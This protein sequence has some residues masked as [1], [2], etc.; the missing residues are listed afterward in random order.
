MCFLS[1]SKVASGFL[2]G[3]LGMVGFAPKFPGWCVSL[4]VCIDTIVCFELLLVLEG[5]VCTLNYI[6]GVSVLVGSSYYFVLR[7]R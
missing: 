2:S 5:N 1:F 3:A 7:E 6:N 4:V